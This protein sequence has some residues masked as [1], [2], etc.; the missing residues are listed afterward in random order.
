MPAIPR[1][2]S[3]TATRCPRHP[4]AQP[5]QAID[6][7]CRRVGERLCD[8]PLADAQLPGTRQLRHVDLHACRETTKRLLECTAGP[9]EG[10]H[11]ACQR[12]RDSAVPACRRAYEIIRPRYAPA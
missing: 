6:K 2:P 4:S 7:G 11:Y 9:P 5:R 8:E 1:L 12:S 3:A 10:G